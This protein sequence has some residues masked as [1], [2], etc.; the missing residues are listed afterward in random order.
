MST[1]HGILHISGKEIM[2]PKYNSVKAAAEAAVKNG[3]SLKW[4][5]LRGAYLKGAY[6]G[7]TN[8]S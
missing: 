3:I 6:L 5:D 1:K 8:T 7:N 2:P 4:A